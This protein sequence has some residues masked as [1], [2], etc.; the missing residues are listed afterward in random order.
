MH[1][2]TRS[3]RLEWRGIVTGDKIERALRSGQNS[4]DTVIAARSQL[5]QVLHLVQLIVTI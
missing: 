5:A 2:H 3:L 1:R 4:V